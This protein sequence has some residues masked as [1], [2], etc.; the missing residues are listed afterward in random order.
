MELLMLAEQRW[1]DIW[2]ATLWQWLCA[3]YSVWWLRSSEALKQRGGRN[4]E[5][6]VGQS[7]R[8][9]LDIVVLVNGIFMFP[10][11]KEPI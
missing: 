8:V 4:G 2:L 9:K 3:A 5:R 10:S 7:Q 11:I 6:S 1:S